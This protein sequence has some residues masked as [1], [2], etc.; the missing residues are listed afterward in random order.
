MAQEISR[1]W[2]YDETKN[3]EYQA[4]EFAE[5]FRTYFSDGLPEL[6]T[7]LQ[8]TADGSGMLI[9]VAYGYASVQGSFYHLK[10][11]ES[12]VKTLAIA[13]AHASYTRI[14]RVV[15]RRD[16]S[17]SVASIVLAILAGTAAATPSAA[18]LTRAGNVYE[19]SLARI[20]IPPGTLSITAG[21]VTDERADNTL[22]GLIE[23]WSVRNR[24]NQDVRTTAS[25]TFDMVTANKVIGAVFQE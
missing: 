15:L 6:G 19:L 18:D 22:C 1:F 8:V 17:A 21:M 23:P 10:D 11:N 3:N 25:P 14:D 2:D 12:G 13:A 7:N 9:K 16:K 5:Y 20:T 24:I 4:D